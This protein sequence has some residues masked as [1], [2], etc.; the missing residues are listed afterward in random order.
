MPEDNKEPMTVRSVVCTGITELTSGKLGVVLQEIID[1]VVSRTNRTVFDEKSCSK[2]MI[3]T[4]AVYNIEFNAEFSSARLAGAKYVGL[5]PNEEDR[6]KWRA[7]DDALKGE[8][9]AKKRQ[10]LDLSDNAI[11]KALDPLRDVWIATNYT[12]RLALE[13]QILAYIRGGNLIGKKED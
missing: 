11:K 12:G 1:G 3:R 4:G 7:Q 5:W 8:R 6:I 13:V 10:K 9:A 2:A